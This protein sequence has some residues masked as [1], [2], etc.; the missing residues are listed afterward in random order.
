[1]L[2]TT[3]PTA[4]SGAARHTNLARPAAALRAPGRAA[5]PRRALL[6]P[7]RAYQSDK[8]EAAA[9]SAADRSS[10]FHALA[11]EVRVGAQARVWQV[12]GQLELQSDQNAGNLVVA[13]W[14]RRLCVNAVLHRPSA[15]SQ[16]CCRWLASW[17]RS[18]PA[19]RAAL[20]RS[21]SA[22]ELPSRV[23]MLAVRFRCNLQRCMVCASA[24]LPGFLAPRHSQQP[25]CSEQFTPSL[26]RRLVGSHDEQG[27]LPPRTD[28]T[29]G[30]CDV[31]ACALSWCHMHVLSASLLTL[32]LQLMGGLTVASPL[33]APSLAQR[34]ATPSG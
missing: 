2:A 17:P 9:A 24:S 28:Q 19:T 18:L 21:W 25:P 23:P 30:A 5:A 31:A 22:G 13:V 10:A 15:P 1:M 12:Q 27:E 29:T 14:C 33:P 34:R 6:L 26:V 20:T 11:K 3:L 7:V 4:C 8:E 32:T 16:H